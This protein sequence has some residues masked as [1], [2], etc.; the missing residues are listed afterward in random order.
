[1][2]LLSLRRGGEEEGGVIAVSG[3]E[4]AS[5][6]VEEA[7]VIIGEGQDENQLP[8]KQQLQEDGSERRIRNDDSVK[9]THMEKGEMDVGVAEL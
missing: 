8:L 9:I 4:E 2:Y 1:M 7:I 3:V 5:F 6:K